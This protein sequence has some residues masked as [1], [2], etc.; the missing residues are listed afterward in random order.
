VLP[1]RSAHRLAAAV[2]QLRGPAAIAGVWAVVTIAAAI[3]ALALVRLDGRTDVTG[4]VLSRLS[5]LPL[6]AI[7]TPL[8]L[9]SAGRLPV[10]GQGRRVSA[11]AIALHLAL[12]SLFI[13]LANVAIRLPAAF[14]PLADGGGLDALTR[15]TLQGVAEFYPAAMVVYGVIVAVG[16]F[17]YPAS[18]TLG[19]LAPSAASQTL[20]EDPIPT[21]LT[22]VAPV[23]ESAAR[24]P[25]SHSAG[26]VPAAATGHPSA[27]RQRDGHVSDGHL[28]V[29]Q[30]NRVHLVPVDDIDWVEAKDNYVVVHASS[31]SYKGR[32]RI[33]D[34]EAQLD[35]RRFVRIHRSTIVHVAKIREVQPLTHGDHAV[36]LRDGKVLRVARSRRQALGEALGMEL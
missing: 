22:P 29:R 34:V 32:E 6:W 19:R 3:Q 30:W 33:S 15:S 4:A 36:I 8:I 16:H 24:E 17:V 13:V 31:R 21:L 28:T 27:G 12:G 25:Q 9:R 7:A 18:T 14:A 35:A 5:I 20:A 11:P 23:L 2:P 1:T 26:V 10:A